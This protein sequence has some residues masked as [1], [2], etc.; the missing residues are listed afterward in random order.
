MGWFD[1]FPFKSK[2]QMDKERAEFEQRI[3]PL[4]LEQRDEA[5]R[6]LRQFFSR[7][8]KDDEVLYAFI[9]SKDSYTRAQNPEDSLKR[10]HTKL[11]KHNK[12]SDNE[13]QVIMALLPLDAGA[14]SL[15]GYPTA[16]D[17]KKQ[18]D[19]PKGNQ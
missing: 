15:E 19:E 16:E 14:E 1:G 9:S 17:I 3:F 6:L 12:F 5:L 13:I 11:R 2:A 4:G 10:I 7:K 18:L 8:R